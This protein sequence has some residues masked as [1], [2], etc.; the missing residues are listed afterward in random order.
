MKRGYVDVLFANVTNYGEKVRHFVEHCNFDM[1]GLAEHHLLKKAAQLEIKKLRFKG[2]QSQ[3][4]WTPATP[5]GK[6]ASGTHGGTCWLARAGHV[7]SA[8]LPDATGQS[9]FQKDL[10]DI[11]IVLWRLQGATLALINVYLDCS[12]GLND[13]KNASKLVQLTRVV[14]SLGVPWAI[15]GD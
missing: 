4:T 1:I 9:V 10:R 8:H 7:T 12:V 6:S 11:S 2:W 3:F 15:L 5:T 14:R 13:P